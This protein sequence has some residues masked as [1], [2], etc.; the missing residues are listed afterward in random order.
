MDLTTFMVAVFCL[1]EDFLAGKW[2]RKP[3]GGIA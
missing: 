1:V 2:L 3:T